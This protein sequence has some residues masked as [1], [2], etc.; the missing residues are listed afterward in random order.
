[1]PR[2]ILA[3]RAIGCLALYWNV[4]RILLKC[5]ARDLFWC[6]RDIR[7]NRCI[8]TRALLKI[9]NAFLPIGPADHLPSVPF[10]NLI[11]LNRC[12]ESRT[13]YTVAN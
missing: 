8:D 13:L 9:L 10:R 1:M 12:S 7:D 2:A 11:F 5:C 3:T 6:N 4:R